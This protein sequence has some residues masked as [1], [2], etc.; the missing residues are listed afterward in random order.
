MAGLDTV[1][2]LLAVR[3][4][5]GYVPESA[6]PTGRCGLANFSH[7]WRGFAGC[8]NGLVAAAVERVVDGLRWALSW[9]SRRGRCRAAIASGCR[10]PGADPRSRH[11]HFDEPTNGL[12]PRQ[13]IE[14][15]ELIRLLA[16]PHGAHEF[17]YPQR[18][19]ED[20]T[21]WR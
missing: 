20:S 16:A 15:R 14:M 4:R 8:P 6:P 19:G 13:I 9:T 17:A 3:R 1:R 18:G 12:D 5:I 21:G 10:R 7:S 11:P 2:D